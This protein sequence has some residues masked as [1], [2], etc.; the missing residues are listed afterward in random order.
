MTSIASP[1]ADSA[2]ATVRTRRVRSWP[3]RSS[4]IILVVIRIKLMAKRRSSM[5]IKV[6]STFRLLRISPR[7][8]MTKRARASVIM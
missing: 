3:M 7:M 1:I 6:I 5:L 4:C 2:A 8:P